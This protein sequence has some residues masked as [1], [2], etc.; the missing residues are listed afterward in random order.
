MGHIPYIFGCCRMKWGLFHIY[1]PPPA[2]GHV[3]LNTK[4]NTKL[5]IYVYLHNINNSLF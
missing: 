5:N 4:L 2:K 1:T 3:K